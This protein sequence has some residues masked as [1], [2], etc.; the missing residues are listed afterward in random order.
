MLDQLPEGLT[1][2]SKLRM[3][4]KKYS[5]DTSLISDNFCLIYIFR[6]LIALWNLECH[7]Y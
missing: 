4:L 3:L 5:G 2:T 7:K 6:R 1:F